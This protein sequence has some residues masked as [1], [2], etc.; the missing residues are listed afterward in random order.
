MGLVLIEAICELPESKRDRV[1]T[2]LARAGTAELPLLHAALLHG[3]VTG[4]WR[5]A[6]VRTRIREIHAD[7]DAGREV[8]CGT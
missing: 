3:K 6:M 1:A 5:R 8:A 7:L 4:H 2:A